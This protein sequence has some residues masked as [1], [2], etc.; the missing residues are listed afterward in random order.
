MVF[1]IPFLAAF[2]AY[3]VGSINGAIIT[4]RLIYKDDVRN[5]GSKNAGLTNF[6]RTYGKKSALFVLLIDILKSAVPIFLAGLLFTHFLDFATAE[7]RLLIRRIFAGLCTMLGHCYPLFYKFRGG[8]GVLS[9]ATTL[10]FVNLPL[11]AVLI[12]LFILIVIFTRYIS[13]GSVLAGLLFPIGCFVLDLPP[14]VIILATLCGGLLIFKH[15][16]NITR[17]IKGTENKF[18]L[19]RKKEDTQ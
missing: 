10:F 18:S 15:H 6:I 3:T 19:R 8:K 4:S 13:L 7:E 11:F 16:G 1:L 17:L 2:V 5:H 14:M 9:G 12:T